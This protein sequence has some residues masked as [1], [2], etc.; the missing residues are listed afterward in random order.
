MSA[1]VGV[2]ILVA[3]RTE[4]AALEKDTARGQYES[5]ADFKHVQGVLF[6]M[7]RAL[8]LCKKEVNQD[9]DN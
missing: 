9:D 2:R 7:E 8:E 3:L 6:G 5:I 4:I 1:P